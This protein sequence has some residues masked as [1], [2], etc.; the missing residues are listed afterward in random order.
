MGDGVNTKVVAVGVIVVLAIVIGAYIYFNQPKPETD[1]WAG[2]DQAYI[3][4]F[5]D[6]LGLANEVYFVMDL[7]G[8]DV[9]TQRNIMQCSAD[10]AF[11]S[12]LGGKSKA[13]YSLDS[14]CLRISEME[15]D[16][17]VTLTL[18]QCLEEIDAARDD[19]TKSIFYVRKSNE[20]MIFD[21]ELVIGMNATY[22]YMGCSISAE[23]QQPAVAVN[24]TMMNETWQRLTN[25]TRV[26]SNSTNGTSN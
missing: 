17:P 25:A 20:T 16:T 8:A 18:S 26:D 13:I 23:S 10:L 1:P 14:E 11:S 2:K 21:N 4:D 19:F 3:E 12:S 24:E 22:T 7:R 6:N 5:S 15:G 9:T